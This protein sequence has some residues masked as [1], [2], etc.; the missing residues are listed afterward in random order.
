M[1]TSKT[2]DNGKKEK[3]KKKKE[4][5]AKTKP[6]APTIST[7]QHELPVTPNPSDF[8][9]KNILQK[10][11]TL[12]DFRRKSK[13]NQTDPEFE[14]SSRF[15]WSQLSFRRRINTFI[16][17]SPLLKRSTYLKHTPSL[18]SNL[19]R[20]SDSLE[21]LKIEEDKVF[22]SVPGGGGGS[23]NSGEQMKKVLK[24]K[25]RSKSCNEFNFEGF[26]SG[27]CAMCKEAAFS[28]GTPVIEK[29]GSLWSLPSSSDKSQNGVPMKRSIS[30]HLAVRPWTLIS[31]SS[32]KL[33][34][35]TRD[36][37]YFPQNST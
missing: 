19:N 2:N 31:V 21:S 17:N 13:S 14:D 29:T 9:A 6:E 3:K 20:L 27:L 36:T 24:Y 22:T 23:R 34:N 16:Q 32:Q 28:P 37:E 4:G 12:I 25:S 26:E 5:K 8:L 7:S 10:S 18:K 30:L 33:H 35:F 11:K 15:E 1:F